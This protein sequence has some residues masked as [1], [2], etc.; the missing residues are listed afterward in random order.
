VLDELTPDSRVRFA[1]ALLNARRGE[2]LGAVK[3]RAQLLKEDL[4]SIEQYWM[5][6]LGALLAAAVRQDGRLSSAQQQR[7]SEGY[8]A[9][10]M[11]ALRKAAAAGYFQTAVMRDEL[12]RNPELASLRVRPEFAQLL[13]EVDSAA[14]RKGTTD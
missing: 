1:R 8:A 11:A 5:A 2:Y 4:D 3:E 7:Q 10:G 14:K 12:R 9:A 6:T 13:A